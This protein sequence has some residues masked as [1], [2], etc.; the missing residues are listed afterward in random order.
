MRFFGQ[1]DWYRLGA[2]QIVK[3]Q[4]KLSG[5]WHGG[6]QE[7]ELVAT[8]FALLFL[9]KGRAPVLINKLQHPPQQDW[10]NDPDDVRNIVSIVSEDW[11]SLLAWQVV[12]PRIATIQE[13]LQ[14]PIV[15]FNGHEAPDFSVQAKENLRAFVEQG[16]FIFADACCGS[17]AFDH[18]FKRLMR[19][20]FPEP[21]FELGHFLRTIRSG[22]PSICSRRTPTLFWGSSTAAA[23][24][25]FT[26]RP[27]FLATGTSRAQP[28]QPGRHQGDQGRPECHRLRH[29]PRDAG[30]QADHSRRDRFQG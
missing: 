24:S 7:N 26:L 23:Q 15:F 22:D 18:G 17:P 16:G 29:R 10:N 20:L 14:A 3:E 4:K 27:T 12:D 19:E 9:A 6:G 8:S 21:G 13:L 28:G 25:S 30:R 1:N 11:K 2:E 5:F